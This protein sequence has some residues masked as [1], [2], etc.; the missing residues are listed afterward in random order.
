MAKVSISAAARLAGVSR[1]HLY[2]RFIDTGRLT[3]E[4]D[5]CGRPAIDTDELSEVFAVGGD[6]CDDSPEVRR[7]RAAPGVD[8]GADDRRLTEL[9]SRLAIAL[10]LLRDR[11]GQ[12]CEAR[13]RENWMRM[14]IDALRRSAEAGRA[15]AEVRQR[16]I[17][18]QAKSHLG[19]Y[20]AALAAVRRELA[21]ERA[22]SF[23]SRLF[24]L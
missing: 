22:R 19:K 12:L 3:V 16:A 20:R 10:G 23:W 13:E 17:V 21:A 7:L 4:R 24:G 14:H 9:E 8:G 6:A 5:E 15:E 11:E 2:K 18:E 1:Q